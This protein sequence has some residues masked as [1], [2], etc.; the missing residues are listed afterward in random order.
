MPSNAAG[1]LRVE[2]RDVEILYTRAERVYVRGVLAAG[3]R[4]VADGVHRI[5]PG[6][7]VRVADT[8]HA[9]TPTDPHR[10][11]AAEER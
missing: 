2:R 1:I 8:Q 3:E 11:T 7:T 10:G 5:V 6:Q 4:V 9:L